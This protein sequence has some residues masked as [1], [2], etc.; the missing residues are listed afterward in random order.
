MSE[1][2]A[3]ITDLRAELAVARDAA[4]LAAEAILARYGGDAE[5]RYK[6]PIEPVTEADMI[7]DELLRTHLLGA[8][9]TDAWLSEESADDPV[10]LER[11]RVWIVDPLDGTREFIARRPEFAVS[12]ALA[13]DGVAVL[14]VIVNPVTRE[15][16]WAIRGQGAWIEVGTGLERLVVSPAGAATDAHFAV[17]RTETRQGHFQRLQHDLRLRPIGGMAHKLAL[18]ARGASEGTFTLQNR[19]E[20]DVAAGLLLVTEAGGA[21][22]QLD[23]TPFV[24]NQPAPTFHSVVATNG[25][26]HDEL[27]SVLRRPGHR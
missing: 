7:A 12:V 21:V 10:R 2:T 26:V 13:Q 14:G 16:F 18:V 1:A 19:C 25:Q 27:L 6:T 17:S 9:P 24:F 20:W 3:P 15:L 22:S 8:F 11:S 23:G 5:V 4:R